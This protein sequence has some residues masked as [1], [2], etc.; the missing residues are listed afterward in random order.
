MKPE[1]IERI[2]EILPTDLG[3][4][5]IRT[6]I[7]SDILRRS[8]F[9][10]RMASAP[11]LEKVRDLCTQL[12]SGEINESTVRA[13]L[14][15]CLAS[16]GHSPLDGGGLEN[17]A[18]IRRLNL[19]ID[20]QREMASSVARITEQTDATVYL[21]PA[22][23]LTRFET[24]AVPRTDWALRWRAAGE[25]VGWHGATPREMVALKDSPIWQALGDGVGGFKDTLGNPYPPFAYSSGL[26]W[27]EVDRA[28]CIRL[29]LIDGN[30]AESTNRPID[31]ST[32]PPSLAPTA[33]Q[34][35]NARARYGFDVFAGLD[36]GGI[37]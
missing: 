24:R 30:S 9:S 7:A 12:I 11:Y 29:G 10:A 23:K 35:A 14:E 1:D 21:Y 22:W 37:V 28:T 26:D 31:E 6:Q 36:F 3:S 20:T 17:P 33:E 19:I 2:K 15:T 27:I 8:V 5:E 25:S 18:S 32:N 34:V 13:G 16:M 4:E